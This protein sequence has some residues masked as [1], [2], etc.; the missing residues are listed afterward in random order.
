MI[1]GMN[2]AVQIYMSALNPLAKNVLSRK[3]Q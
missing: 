2:D 1:Y 3:F